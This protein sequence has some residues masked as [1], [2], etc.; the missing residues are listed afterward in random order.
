MKILLLT[1]LFINIAQSSPLK[2]DSGLYTCDSGNEDS[3]C[4]QILIPSF[5]GDKLSTITVEYVGW[6][7]S[8]GPYKYSCLNDVCEDA[9]LKFEFHD[10]THYRWE[11]KQYKIFC[12]FAKK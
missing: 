5:S 12:E 8:M 7:G 2:P 1:L 3:I 11:N 6:C 10:S 4:D 9:G